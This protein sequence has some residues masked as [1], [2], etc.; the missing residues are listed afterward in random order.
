MVS[1]MKNFQF[2]V[3]TCWFEFPGFLKE[4]VPD[5]ITAPLCDNPQNTFFDAETQFTL[6]ALHEHFLCHTPGLN[7]HLSCVSDGMGQ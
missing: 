6:T 7:R 3:L 1:N 2:L 4:V 5:V